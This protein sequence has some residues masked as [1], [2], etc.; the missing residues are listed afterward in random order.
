MTGKSDI[1]KKFPRGPGM[2]DA[3][4]FDREPL[5]NSDFYKNVLKPTSGTTIQERWGGR[6][7]S[8]HIVDN[9]ADPIAK[10]I[11]AEKKAMTQPEEMP[12]SGPKAEKKPRLKPKTTNPSSKSGRLN[13][14]VTPGKWS[15][16]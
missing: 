3:K 7:Q 5:R 15:T 2:K 4:Q 6:R 13:S 1:F 10:I 8:E 9:T 11:A 14:Q 16:K 12:Q